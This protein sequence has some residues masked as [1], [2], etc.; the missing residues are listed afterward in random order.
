MTGSGQTP[1]DNRL[2]ADAHFQVSI[3]G[4]TPVEVTV[5]ASSTLNNKNALDLVNDVNAALQAAGITGVVAAL[6]TPNPLLSGTTPAPANG[7]LLADSQFQLTI[8][9]DQP[10]TV[11][12]PRS[13]TENNATPLALIDDLNTALQA[14]LTGAGLPTNL[15]AVRAGNTV[16]SMGSGLPIPASGRL[17]GDATFSLSIPS[18]ATTPAQNVSVTVPQSTTQNNNSASD[19]VD[20]FNTAAAG[21]RCLVGGDRQ[22]GST[23]SAAPGTEPIAA[24]GQVGADLHFSLSING[25]PTVPVV[26]PLSETS[27]DLN[28]QDLVAAFN[29]ALVAAG[30]GEIV[31]GLDG[32]YLQLTAALDAGINQVSLT[33][34]VGDAMATVLGFANFQQS[35]AP[36][37]LVL[38]SPLSADLR[39][40][41]L[42]A[43]AG[44]VMTVQLG[45]QTSQLAV[46]QPVLTFYPPTPQAYRMLTLNAPSDDPMLT[47]LGFTNG[48]SAG[49]GRG[50]L[51]LTATGADV[52]TFLDITAD[53]TDPA[54]GQLGLDDGKDLPTVQLTSRA[55]T[56]QYFIEQASIDS[57]VELYNKAQFQPAIAGRFGFLGMQGSVLVTSG[58]ANVATQLKDPHTGTAGGRLSLSDFLAL[59]G[60]KSTTGIL[61]AGAQPSPTSCPPPG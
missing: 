25:G 60:T 41:I 14:A 8:D 61:D 26:I 16:Q 7:Q 13:A 31:A 53:R 35:T 15:V 48:Q 4:A 1:A 46:S 47:Q 30:L 38:A 22:A 49:S 11:M 54:V 34:P 40:L 23:R 27:Q 36:P 10:I 18:T 3:D 43:D 37:R 6:D 45:F 9:N 20:D 57:D 55:L 59:T 24:D 29:T 33:V 5:P 56:N 58:R 19:L 21:G 12:V 28:P 44:S 42:S 32:S 2:T 52:A 17:D 50:N 39:S 51:T